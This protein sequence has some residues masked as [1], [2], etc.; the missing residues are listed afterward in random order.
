MIILVGTGFIAGVVWSNALSRRLLR[1]H[2][3]SDPGF[4]REA[5]HAQAKMLRPVPFWYCDSDLCRRNRLRRADVA[6]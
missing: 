4:W 3:P 6:C 2:A 1:S 5:F